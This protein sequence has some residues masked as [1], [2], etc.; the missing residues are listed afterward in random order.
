MPRQWLVRAAL[1]AALVPFAP[2]SQRATADSSMPVLMPAISIDGYTFS[3]PSTYYRPTSRPKTGSYDDT[4]FVA[5]DYVAGRTA[6]FSRTR[7]ETLFT[8]AGARSA[9]LAE[10]QTIL[11]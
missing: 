10:L 4:I 7:A 11:G 1:G 9:F 2:P 3:V 6:S 5:A 8:D